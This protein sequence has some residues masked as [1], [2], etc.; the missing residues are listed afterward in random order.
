MMK[1]LKTLIGTLAV[2]LLCAGTATAERLKYGDYMPQGANEYS[3]TA[4]WMGNEINK[5]AAGKHSVTMLWGG[6]VVKVGE[7]PT[8]VENKII[9]IGPLVTPYFPDQFPINNAIPFFWPQ[10]KTQAELGKLMLKWHG[11]HPEFAAELAKYK[12]KLVSVR[13]L[14]SYGIICTKP[15]RTLADFKGLRIRSYGIALPAMLEAL[16]AVPVSMADVDGYEALSNGILDCSPGDP[17]L[18]VGWKWADVAKYYIDVPMGASWGHIL[19]MNIDKYNALPEDLKK[20][21]DDMKED[22]LNEFLRV[23]A[24]SIE[25]TRAAWKANGKVEVI[26]FPKDDFLKATLEN[27]KVQSVRAS[28]ITRATKAGMPEATAKKVVDELTK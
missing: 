18:T 17:P 3:R 10:P 13:P 19:V 27:A 20:I 5:R 22:Y 9:D 16:G 15:V 12:L 28:W 8:A 23:Y 6:T 25:D 7:V 24:K 21:I 14:P 11:E 4:E 2:S 1:S 26:A